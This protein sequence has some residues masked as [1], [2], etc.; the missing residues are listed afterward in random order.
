[1]DHYNLMQE[2][3]EVDWDTLIPRLLLYATSTIRRRTWYGIWGGPV[4]RGVEAEDFVLEAI[5]R[6]M[7]GHRAWNPEKV[8]LY[9]HLVGTIRSLIYHACHS[10]ENSLTRHVQPSNVVAFADPHESC[11]ENAVRRRQQTA[12]LLEYLTQQAPQLRLLAELILIFELSRTDELTDML[13]VTARELDNL[14]RRLRCAMERYKN[15]VAS[16]DSVNVR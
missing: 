10:S 13:G 9:G 16:A 2:L 6:T 5:E 1:M 11:P 14:K 3:N 8:D 12:A 7:S 15:S 4:V